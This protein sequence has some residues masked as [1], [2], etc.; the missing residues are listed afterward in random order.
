MKEGER[1]GIRFAI[2]TSQKKA[3]VTAAATSKAGTGIP[4]HVKKHFT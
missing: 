2:A 4:R 1:V 3:A